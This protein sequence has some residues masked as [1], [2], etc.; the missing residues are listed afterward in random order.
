MKKSPTQEITAL[1]LDFPEHSTRISCNKKSPKHTWKYQFEEVRISLC[2]SLIFLQSPGASASRLQV[3]LETQSILGWMHGT[4]ECDMLLPGTTQDLPRT[5]TGI[6]ATAALLSPGHSD[7]P[8]SVKPF[9]QCQWKPATTSSPPAHG[10]L[11]SINT[12]SS[13]WLTRRWGLQSHSFASWR[14]SA[15]LQTYWEMHEYWTILS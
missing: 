8:S 11:P 10:N 15:N 7:N 3:S 9:W 14:D 4:S 6:T 5:G 1:H 12:E 13:A 2:P